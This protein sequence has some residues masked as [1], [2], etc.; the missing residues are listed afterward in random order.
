MVFTS[1]ERGLRRK[2]EVKKM[3]TKTHDLNHEL[4]MPKNYVSLS[5]DE[6]VY[7][8]GWIW[9]AI[10]VVAGLAITAVGMAT[11]NDAVKNFGTVV[12]VA[13]VISSGV[14][15]AYGVAQLATVGTTTMGGNVAVTLIGAPATLVGV[16]DMIKK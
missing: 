9:S 14:G 4:V 15:I 7:D 8:G 2:E 3:L 16:V 1:R 13:G 11:G 5:E 6:M 10:A 12:T